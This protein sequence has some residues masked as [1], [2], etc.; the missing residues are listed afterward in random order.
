[1]Q[2]EH[3]CS[4]RRYTYHMRRGA[5][6]F[7]LIEIMV[8]LGILGSIFVMFAAVSGVAQLSRSAQYGDLALRIAEN[9]LEELRAL[10]YAS[11]PTSGSFT[12]SRTDGLPNA[13]SSI[14]LMDHNA[15]TKHIEV[16][17]SWQA[18]GEST[19]DVTLRTLIT[20]VGGL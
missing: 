15:S 3:Y 10:P 16:T 5:R 18:P 4:L 20:Q 11:L 1:M 9:K 8:S 2:R 7:S 14:V 17:V 13:S 6:G 12:D 19:R